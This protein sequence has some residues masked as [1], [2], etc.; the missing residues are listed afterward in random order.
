LPE[1]QNAIITYFP[2]KDIREAQFYFVLPQPIKKAVFFVGPYFPVYRWKCLDI[3]HHSWK[4]ANN[5]ER[6]YGSIFP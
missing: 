1:K 4:R 2:D 3:P 5:K 6:K